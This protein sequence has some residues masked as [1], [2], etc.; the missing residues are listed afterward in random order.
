MSPQPPL[1]PAPDPFQTLPPE[2]LHLIV[3]HFCAHCCGEY[4]QP[5]K[6][7]STVQDTTTLYNLCLVSPHLRD[8][9]QKILFHYFGVESICPLSLGHGW[10]WRLEPFLRT[11]ASRPDLARSVKIVGLHWRLLNQ[12]SFNGGKVIFDHCAKSLA[13]SAF[14]VFL[15]SRSDQES[16]RNTIRQS[17][18]LRGS[19]P[20]GVRPGQW[21]PV[22][23]SELLAMLLA[24][25][26]NISYLGVMEDAEYFRNPSILEG[27][28]WRLDVS[29]PTL[30]ALGI[31]GVGLKTL[32]SDYRMEK[33]L[34]R[35]TSLETFIMGGDVDGPV[36]EMTS[37][38][39]LHILR[40][41]RHFPTTGYLLKCTG[42]LE[43][44][45]YT[46]AEPDISTVVRCLDLPRFHDSLESIRLDFRCKSSEEAIQPMPS[47]KL[48][49]K[50]KAIFLPARAIWGCYSSRFEP[51]SLTN[52]LPPS[53]ES[54]TLLHHYTPTSS[55]PL[56]EDMLRLLEAKPTSFTQLRTIISDSTQVCNP[57]LMG[58]FKQVGVTVI[59]Q[60]LP[61]YTRRYTGQEGHYE[62]ESLETRYP[63]PHEM[64]PDPDL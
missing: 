60:E 39:H 47:L 16:Q 33:L 15:D 38:K 13:T 56:C 41:G 21:L 48:F 32:E 62:D 29:V 1:N 24:L 44:L 5:F 55:G 8:T 30:D 14:S 18:L 63:W 26:P 45:S 23:A 9:S 11:V 12:L 58:L 3:S 28:G 35:A 54:L 34:T 61:R 10:K 37:L 2:V 31:A 51:Q 22:V 40:W 43:T 7:K 49:T 4:D 6:V 19:L 50:L 52:I 53:I 20:R 57:T 17:F 27:R 36:P 25:L 59:F 64:S 46:A 42:Q